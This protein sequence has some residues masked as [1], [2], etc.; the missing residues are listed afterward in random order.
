MLLNLG[1]LVLS[2]QFI[3]IVLIIY[4]VDYLEAAAGEVGLFRQSWDVALCRGDQPRF[5]NRT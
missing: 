4:Y 3:V 5:H 1:D 2:I